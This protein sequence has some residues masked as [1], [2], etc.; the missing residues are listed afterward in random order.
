M[1]GNTLAALLYLLF[2]YLHGVG[3]FTPWRL[4]FILGSLP[5]LLVLILL[6]KA[7]ESPAWLAARERKRMALEP[8]N[9]AMQMLKHLPSLA[10][11]TLVMTAFM[12]LQSWHTG[13]VSDVS[14]TRLRSAAGIGIVGLDSGE[15]AERCWAGCVS[16]RT[17]SGWGGGVRL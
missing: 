16:G 4:L 10:Y 7:E 9:N 1:S 6:A 17:R 2:P 12:K 8:R 5:A 13:S 3:A 15:L 11:L 14:E